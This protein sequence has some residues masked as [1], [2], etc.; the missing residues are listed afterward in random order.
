M[1]KQ[2]KASALRKISPKKKK[3]KPFQTTT[4]IKIKRVYFRISETRTIM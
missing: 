4:R 2:G 3:K 1:T